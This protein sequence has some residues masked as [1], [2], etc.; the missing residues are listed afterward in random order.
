MDATFVIGSVG[1][2][3]LF[4]CSQGTIGAILLCASFFPKTFLGFSS[5]SQAFQPVVVEAG[6]GSTYKEF[7]V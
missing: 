2:A 5:L 4:R 7:S 3:G 1:A 6:L